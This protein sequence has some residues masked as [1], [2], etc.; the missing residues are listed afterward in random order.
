MQYE[1][2]AFAGA[3]GRCS[4][5]SLRIIRGH[6]GRS[7]A[8]AADAVLKAA[9]RGPGGVLAL[10]LGLLVFVLALASAAGIDLV[11][12]VVTTTIW[13]IRPRRWRRYPRATPFLGGLG[14]VLGD[15]RGAAGG[16]YGRCGVVEDRA[17]PFC[18]PASR[19]VFAIAI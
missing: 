5:Q 16:A 9:D 1:Q 17:G 13:S 4:A 11:G 14:A 2:R 6:H 18:R 19:L 15:L 3:A 12:W 8:P 10:W 7:K